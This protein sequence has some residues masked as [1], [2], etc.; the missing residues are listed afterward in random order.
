[1]RKKKAFTKTTG[2]YFFNVNMGFRNEITISRTTRKEAIF[3]FHK[4]LKQNK[5]C[6][7]LGQWNGD[8]FVDTDIREVA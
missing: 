7:W 1:M 3:A 4:Y 8:Q 2:H 6:E 5:D